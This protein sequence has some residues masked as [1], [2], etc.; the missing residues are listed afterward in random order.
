MLSDQRYV[1]LSLE[2]HL[3]F[4]RIMKEHA[5]FL[6][7][8]FTPKNANL[9]RE[10][11]RYKTNFERLLSRAVDLSSGVIRP[12][13]LSSGEIVTD[14]TLGSEQKTQN[15]TG[16][17]IN[18]SITVREAQLH[19]GTNPNITPAMVDSVRRI[20]QGISGVLNGLINFKTQLLNDVLSCNVFTVNYPLLIEHILREAR[21]YRDYLNDIENGQDIDNKDPRET[22]LFWDQI[23]MEH[24]LFIRGLL[25]P[26]ENQLID[27][28]DN[29]AN[30]YAVLLERA[31][32]A[33]DQTLASVTDETLRETMR[34]KD[35][36][37]AGTEGIAACKIR[38]I[39]LPL[40]ADHVLREANHYIRLLRQ[41]PMN[42]RR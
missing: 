7:A 40:L 5:L 11:D 42:R 41:R 29:F 34:F 27:T 13:V 16:I 37:Q 4:A 32:N 19:S 9:A 36:K 35:F 6:E 18:Q 22:E 14:F 39:I 15:F 8:G 31:R 26:T 30:E 28:S 1:V 17:P 24:A 23:M 20:N 33:T 21:L 25:D 2:L 3:F 12:M 38:S 10:A